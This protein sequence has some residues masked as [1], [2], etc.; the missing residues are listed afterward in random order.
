MKEDD[1]MTRAQVT[2]LKYSYLE[3]D[4]RVYKFEV[5]DKY[6]IEDEAD[7]LDAMILKSRLLKEKLSGY[8]Q[9]W[10]KNTAIIQ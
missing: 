2:I 1:W 3:G 9:L 6:N 7:R 5:M 10:I 8:Q 4:K